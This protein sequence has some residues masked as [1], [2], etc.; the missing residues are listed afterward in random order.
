[1]KITLKSKKKAIF[2]P[3]ES[4]GH[5]AKA[6]E[7]TSSLFNTQIGVCPKCQQPMGKAKLKMPP[8][9]LF[10]CTPC[11]VSSPMLDR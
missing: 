1:M 9:E 3:F 5:D 8:D 6:E 10:Y 2:N 11:R 4:I 7:S